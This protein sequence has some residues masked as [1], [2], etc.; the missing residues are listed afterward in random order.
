[1]SETSGV[2]GYKWSPLKWERSTTPN[3]AY[4]AHLQEAFELRHRVNS[5]GH[6]AHSGS[7]HDGCDW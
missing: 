2:T 7:D 6:G 4:E 1:M 5:D 3:E